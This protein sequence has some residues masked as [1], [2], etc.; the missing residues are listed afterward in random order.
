MLPNFPPE[1]L[2]L[3]AEDNPQAFIAIRS[4]HRGIR[5]YM[6]NGIKM[7]NLLNKLIILMTR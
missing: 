6:K 1:L 3:I 2:L 5:D 4:L 7:D